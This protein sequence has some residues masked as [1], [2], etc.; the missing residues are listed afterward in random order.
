V[1]TTPDSKVSTSVEGMDG[2]PDPVHVLGSV[3]A[4][5]FLGRA[6]ALLDL[7]RNL[8]GA[9]GTVA[10]A[11]AVVVARDDTPASVLARLHRLGGGTPTT[12]AAIADRLDHTP[13]ARSDELS[14]LVAV[15]VA[16]VA[17]AH[18]LAWLAGQMQRRRTE[19]AGLRT[20]GIRPRAVRRAYLKEAMILAAIVLVT[21]A[22]TA[23]ATTVPLLEPMGLV[24]GWPPAPVLR[25]AIRPITLASVV[26]GVSVVTAALCAIVFTRFGRGA[27]PSAL[28]AADR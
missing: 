22:I 1:L 27:R 19:V 11:R 20:A 14:L 13:E 21:A 2:T 12:Y 24:G 23:V 5:P 7:G 18:L 15:G 10:A 17:L 26:V 28:R 6:G 3:D 4:V 25:P 16:L 9:V 8:R